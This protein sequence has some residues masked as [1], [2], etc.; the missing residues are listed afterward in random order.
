MHCR[1]ALLPFASSP[2]PTTFCT[3]RGCVVGPPGAALP[4]PQSQD[5]GC[6]VGAAAFPYAA[7][8]LSLFLSAETVWELLPSPHGEVSSWR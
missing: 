6:S 2:E 7:R 3:E 4:A 5:R 8:F 1:A